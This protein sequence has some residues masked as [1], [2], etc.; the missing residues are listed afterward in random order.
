MTAA[1]LLI[2]NADDFGRT[3][4]VNRG[5]AEAHRHGIVT[6]ATLMVNQPAAADAA[7]L[8]RKNPRLGVGLHVT[9]T[10]GGLPTLPPTQ[11]PSLVNARGLLP[12]TPDALA[13]ADPHEVLLEVRAQ[14]KRFRELLGRLPTHLDSHHHAQRMP[15]VLEALVTL[16]WETGLPVRSVSAD[17]R[18]RFR[19]EGMATPDRFVD[20]FY[21]DEA[22]L[23]GLLRALAELQ[24]G[25]TE[26][27]CHPAHV[28]DELRAGSSYAQPR[29]RELAILTH[30]EIRQQI[31]AT[32]V[33]LTSFEL[34]AK[35]PPIPAPPS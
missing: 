5:I 17:M 29:A 32:G 25:T 31:Q 8:A 19:R 27:M 30:S 20:S 28:D 10:G 13:A 24:P 26:L 18:L 6:S 22:T 12:H 3:P 15:A 16:A 35:G 34:W 7:A 14:V 2:V 9:L 21:A 1:K 11:V 4:G 23:E 33:R